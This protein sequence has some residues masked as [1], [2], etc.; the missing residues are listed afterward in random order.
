MIQSYDSYEMSIRERLFYT[1]CAG[2]FI[3]A[4]AF[5][6]YRSVV[7][8]LLLTPL[9][10]LYP[11]IKTKEIIKR[12]KKELNIQFKDMLYSL[13]SS[14][15]A[16]RTIEHA[17]KEALR[18]L[19]VLYPEP[20]TFILVEIKRIISRLDMNETLEHALSEFAERASL[21]DVDNFVSVIN[22]SKR[23]GGNISEI[24]RN[25]SAIISDRIE[26]GQEVDMML[27]ERKFEQK[28]LN[29]VPVLMILLLSVSSPEYIYPVFSTVAGRLTMSVSIILIAA[30]W[31]ISS[32]VCDIKL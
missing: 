5:I 21:E 16:G 1:A 12:R 15:S 9:A 18:D 7:F 31:F 23:S 26:V 3:F 24:I 10:L 6:F 19:S 13:A 32:K 17:F 4:I 29:A 22:I 8:S 27:A 30:A 28:V 25:T 20:S 11:R 14:V 2:V